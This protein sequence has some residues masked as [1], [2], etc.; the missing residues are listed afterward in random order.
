MP[1]PPTRTLACSAGR[2]WR[3]L[4]LAADFRPLYDRRRRLFH[5]GLRAEG[6]HLD[7]GHYDLLASESRLCSLV[8]IAKGDVPPHH[9]ATLGRPLFA[10]GSPAWA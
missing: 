10:S 6:E 3:T 7:A 2:A 9:W 8:A 1:S 5:I 4:A